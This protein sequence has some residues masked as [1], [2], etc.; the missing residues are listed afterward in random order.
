LARTKLDPSRTWQEG[1]GALRV[2]GLNSVAN[3]VESFLQRTSAVSASPHSTAETRTEAM[4]IVDQVEAAI[5][6]RRRGPDR[7]GA[8]SI[9]RTSHRQKPQQQHERSLGVLLFVIP[10]SALI[11]SAPQENHQPLPVSRSLTAAQMESLL[12]EANQLFQNAAAADDK[13]AAE[14]EHAF[15]RA[16]GKYEL[17]LEAGV[18]NAALY[19]NLGNAYFQAKKFALAK[20]NYLRSLKLAPGD[21]KSR[22]N[23]QEADA[24]LQPVAADQSDSVPDFT[25]DSS[26]VRFRRHLRSVTKSVNRFIA[27]DRLALI[28][29]ISSVV[30][31]GAGII[32][33]L[34][35]RVWF[36]P[37]AAIFLPLS[38]VSATIVV[39]QYRELSQDAAVVV[40]RSS[41]L[42]SADGKEF[43]FVPGG[44]TAEG[45]K[46]AVLR[47]RNGWFQVRT[48]DNQ[49]GWLPA[50]EIE[51]L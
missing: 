31:W 36:W 44:K 1:V 18:K 35:R 45:V 15:L 24:R 41:Q 9:G 32:R 14:S 11:H 26:S 22:A 38:V 16:A 50:S 34:G 4:A 37:I 19:R 51:R 46:V 25:A 2:S 28:A 10:A 3:E 42:R 43:E 49:T 6:A 39:A 29:V 30:F 23:L 47:E 20:A 27:V 12:A 40:G 7:R 21:R 5:A 8:S 48:S 13:N 17:L 33:L